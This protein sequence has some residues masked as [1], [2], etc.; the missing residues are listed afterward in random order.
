MSG[1]YQGPRSRVLQSGPAW[2][3][4]GL[5]DRPRHGQDHDV[6]HR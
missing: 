5:R 2:P 3:R 6:H 4:A 1:L